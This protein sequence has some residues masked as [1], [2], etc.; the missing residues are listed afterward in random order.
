MYSTKQKNVLME[1]LKQNKDRLLSPD[2]ILKMLDLENSKC[3][4]ATLYRFLDNL[5]LTKEVRKCYNQESNRFE[6]QLALSDCSNH[7]HLKCKGCGIVIHL[8]CSH[9][10][11]YLSHISKEHGFLIDNYESTI[12]GLCPKCRGN[13]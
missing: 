1:V 10:E 5:V 7:L 8:C 2:E 11:E 3:S 4:K 9:T 13:I 12:Y 6:Y